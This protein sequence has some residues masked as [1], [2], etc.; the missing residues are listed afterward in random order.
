ME[1]TREDLHT[2]FS[3]FFRTDGMT[4]SEAK[5]RR[6]DMLSW[7]ILLAIF[8]GISADVVAQAPAEKMDVGILLFEG[9]ELLDFAGP[10]EVFI[11]A[12]HG[13]AFRVFTIA[14]SDKPVRTMGGIRLLPDYAI[15]EAPP[16]DILVVPGGNMS[17]A[18]TATRKWIKESSEHAKVVM[19]VCMGAFLLA[20]VGLLD[21]TEATT[22]R[23]GIEG[24]RRAAPACKVCEDRRVVESGKI[25]TT[26]GVTAGI[27]GALHLVEKF[28][29]K[30]IAQWT[31]EEW[32]EYKR[33][34]VSSEEA[35]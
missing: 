22:H 12:N 14:A 16:V 32:M 15:A 9:V 6:F 30:K 27:D 17:N 11:V 7:A 5:Q 18:G 34:P 8:A 19:S 25:V 1:P 20:D 23:W 28:Y 31:A 2:N 3:A 10:A 24:L 4:H 35:R 21:N 29:G 33:V 13:N 26:A